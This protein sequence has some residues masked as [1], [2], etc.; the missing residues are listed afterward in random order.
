MDNTVSIGFFLDTRRELKRKGSGEYGVKGALRYMGRR[1]QF[2]TPFA[3]TQSEWDNLENKKIRSDSLKEKKLQLEAYRV[4]AQDIIDT[5]HPFTIEKFKALML[6]K[7]EFAKPENRDV[8]RL[9]MRAEERFELKNKPRTASAYCSARM[10]L[11][12][13]RTKLY[14]EDITP[15]FLQKYENYMVD[16]RKSRTT[17][18]IHLRSLRAIINEAIEEGLMRRD[19]YPFG[20]RKYTVP[21]PRQAKIA[22]PS[23]QIKAILDY[24]PTTPEEQ[25]ARD[26]WVFSYFCGGMN[27]ND[28]CRLKRENIEGNTLSF[29][30][31][32]TKDTSGRNSL[33]IRILLQPEVFEI[34]NRQKALTGYLF[35]VLK[36]NLSIK[37]E[38]ELIQQFTKTTNKYLKHIGAKLHIPKLTTQTARHSFATTL[39]NNG[40]PLAFISKSMGHTTTKTTEIYFGSFSESEAAKYGEMLKALA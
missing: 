11:T 7:G 6:G 12:H 22:L 20:R 14:M 39:R 3:M 34:L 2:A 23:E 35:P 33:P 37:R 30:R 18:G 5:L 29:Y 32:K 1:W 26:I 28:I 27:I 16:C 4:K 38:S 17:V 15:E 9:F 8:Y 19:D 31:N 40:V 21:A 24:S 25:A 13:F 36:P 10:S